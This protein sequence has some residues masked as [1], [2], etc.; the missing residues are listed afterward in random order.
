MFEKPEDY[1]KAIVL[2]SGTINGYLY[3]YD[4]DHPLALQAG[5]VYLHR[6][7]ASVK[8]GR[9][10]VRGE[11]VHHRDGNIKNNNPGNLDV[12]SRK[13]HALLHSSLRGHAAREK[14]AC[15]ACGKPFYGKGSR[16]LFC[17]IECSAFS[18]RR[19]ERPSAEELDRDMKSMSW[20]AMGRK[21]GVSDNAVRKWAAA[22]GLK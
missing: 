11:S 8:L 4:P 18:Q 22:Y 17:S 20:L 7:L 1:K 19:V 2:C 16:N 9:W 10:L 5:S 12:M 3:F 21:Y 15:K 14:R 13:E 6:H